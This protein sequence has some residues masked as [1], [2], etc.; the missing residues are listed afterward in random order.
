MNIETFDA[1]DRAAWLAR[2]QKDVTASAIGCLLDVHDYQTPFGLWALK[3]GKI[4]EDPEESPAMKR[5]RLL[6]PVALKV[7]E[8][9]RPTWL[10]RPGTEY[11]RDSDARIGAT[12]DAFAID[13]ERAGTGIVQIKTTHDLIFR[14]KW[15]DPD[16]REIVVPDW[17]ACQA[18]IEAHLTAAAWASVAV[19]VVGM[20]L[21]L[22]VIDIPISER[23][24]VRLRAEVEKFWAMVDSGTAP[25]VE[26][27]RDGRTLARIFS[28]DNGQEI[29]LSGD[30]EV[31]KL[32]D[33]RRDVKAAEKTAKTR[34]EEIDTLLKSRLG[35]AA[36]AFAGRGR[37][38][39]WKL[40]HRK[41]YSV[42]A[43][44]FRAFRVTDKG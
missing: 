26:G 17:I 30:L 29:D 19:L 34:A 38:L 40:Q 32:L 11:F 23:L 31:V 27:A 35:N 42:D 1:S 9:M 3:S 28:D 21:D 24:I 7:L 15:L 18:I 8:E 33:E 10:L 13:P 39:S 41:A 12:P 5:G 25:P 43:N 22:H 36:T 44:S 6:E 14:Q 20:G 2:R 4:T 16:T 37:A